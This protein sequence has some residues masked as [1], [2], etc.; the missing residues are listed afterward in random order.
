MRAT[1]RRKSERKNTPRLDLHINI[2]HIS[3]VQFSTGIKIGIYN[4]I[5]F[6]SC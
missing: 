4:K 1:G 5:D 6:S 2:N 3:N